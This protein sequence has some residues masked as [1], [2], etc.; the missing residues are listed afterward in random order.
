ML[1]RSGILKTRVKLEGLR[2]VESPQKRT[3]TGGKRKKSNFDSI[4]TMAAPTK[5]DLRGMTVDDCI[6]ELDRFIDS[7]LRTSINE[8]TVVH[9][10]GTGA[11]RS[12][13]QKYLRTCSFVKSHRLGIFGEGEDGVTI[14]EL[15]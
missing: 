6:I 11:L 9:G 10:K 14:V 13:V 12:A 5:L 8:F 2:L 15:K 3:D 7:A 4:S 1:F